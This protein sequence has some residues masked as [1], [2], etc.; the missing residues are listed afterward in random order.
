[1]Q[2]RCELE[3]S[4]DTPLRAAGTIVPVNRHVVRWSLFALAALLACTAPWW[5]QRL[6]ALP[7]A[8]AGLWITRCPPARRSLVELLELVPYLDPVRGSSRTGQLVYQFIR[9]SPNKGNFVTTTLEQLIASFIQIGLAKVDTKLSPATQQ[10]IS[11]AVP[12]LV[13]TIASVIV[14]L[15]NDHQSSKTIKVA[16]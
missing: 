7:L 9:N 5:W 8:T 12:A 16:S 6:A 15:A 4:N 11:N 14:D 1:M 13:S 2:T 3:R 10:A